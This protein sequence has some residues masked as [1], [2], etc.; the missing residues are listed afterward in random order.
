M[1]SL[2]EADKRLFEAASRGD[3]AAV[4]H[5][6]QH[7]A[8]V[9][10]TNK[11]GST[12]LYAAARHGHLTV[13][14]YLVQHGADVNAT[15]N[16]DG[17]TALHVAALN[18]DV[19]VVDYLAQQANVDA[20]TQAGETALAWAAFKG[21]LPVVQC[22]LR[23]AAN[24]HATN[25]AGDTALHEAALAGH[26]P[27][28]ACLIQHTANIHATNK[29]GDTVLHSAAR[30]GDLNLA[31]YLLQQGANIHATNQKGQTPSSLAESTAEHTPSE[32]DKRKLFQMAVYLTMF[33]RIDMAD[34]KQDS[35]GSVSRVLDA[36]SGSYYL[37]PIQGLAAAPLLSLA[38]CLQPCGMPDLAVYVKCACFFAN[39]LWRNKRN[40]Q[41]QCA[42]TA[43]EIAA[44]HLY[45]QDS[46]FY[47]HL[48]SML[49]DA[50][51]SV[52]Q[53]WLPYLKLFL[54]GLRKLPFYEGSLFR[55]VRKSVAEQPAQGDMMVWW[56]IAST[57]SS[58][59][60]LVSDLLGGAS[61]SEGTVF[62][63]Q[64]KYAVDISEFSA[65][66]GESV[67]IL[68]PGTILEVRSSAVLGDLSMIHLQET[69]LPM[70]LADFE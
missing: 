42:L 36:D 7:R 35:P 24:I 48:N 70:I 25:Q 39:N 40:Q 12:V 46:P 62:E 44:I 38:E 68:L 16:R 33:Q 13:V 58:L 8:N 14:Q 3:L 50:N 26:L 51:R 37:P 66:P 49:R 45:T 6:L 27:V 2:Q 9:N 56:D 21:H 60:V 22:L 17:S 54:T 31:M 69:D 4:Q 28:L 10:A 30:S 1:N 57:S 34:W 64:A 15:N 41:L 32:H 29:L 11:V 20:T 47:Q 55:G 65:V 18:G 67:R 61:A 23:H 52:L 43:D 59:R 63:I 53:P 5:W 19:H